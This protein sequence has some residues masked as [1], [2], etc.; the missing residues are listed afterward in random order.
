[1]FFNRFDVLILKLIFKKLKKKP[2]F[3]AF[4]SEKCF[5]L[6]DITTIISKTLKA[7]QLEKQNHHCTVS[8]NNVFKSASQCYLAFF[9]IATLTI[10]LD[11]K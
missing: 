1:M 7:F 6:T 11:G 2:Y 9:L 3:N 10:F 8:K 5:K 4:V